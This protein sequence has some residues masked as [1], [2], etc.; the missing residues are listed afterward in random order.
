MIGDFYNKFQDKIA[1]ISLV[2]QVELA[3]NHIELD[4]YYNRLKFK[5]AWT[6]QAIMPNMDRA[7]LFPVYLVIHSDSELPNAL[8]DDL[9]GL[10]NKLKLYLE[11]YPYQ[12]KGKIAFPLI[13]NYKKDVKQIKTP[14]LDPTFFYLSTKAALQIGRPLKRP[15]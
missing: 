3:Y 9:S 12:V 8:M 2:P 4:D 10:I 14:D 11:I 13:K 1:T 6:P 15:G 7:E 5:Q